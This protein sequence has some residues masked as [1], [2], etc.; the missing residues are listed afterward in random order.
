[1]VSASF[2]PLSVPGTPQDVK[3][4]EWGAPPPNANMLAFGNLGVQGGSLAVQGWLFD[5]KNA[6]SPQVLGKQYRETATEDNARLIAHR[7]ADEIIFRLGGGIQG[8]AETKIYF[9]SSRGGYKE[10]WQMDYDG[11][12]QKQ[13]THLGTIALVAARFARRLAHRVLPAYPSR[14]GR[15]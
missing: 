6:Q 5:V 12:N 13:L 7:F 4:A 11:A 1:M 9:V 3:L 14:A 10:I 15:S 8:I 2:Y